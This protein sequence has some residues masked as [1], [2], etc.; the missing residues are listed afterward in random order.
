[1]TAD[2]NEVT[3][4]VVSN[5]NIESEI[6]SE[7][8]VV[9]EEVINEDEP[10]VSSEDEEVP[11]EGEG[12]S[13]VSS[14]EVSEANSEGENEDYGEDNSEDEDESEDEQDDEGED[15]ES[16][17]SSD[18]VESIPVRRSK[19]DIQPPKILTYDHLGEPS[20]QRKF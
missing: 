18:S 16:E 1:M 20:H 17:A 12:E 2:E 14:E 19:R 3:R 13:K 10:E 4:A 5:E 7:N 15:D 6:N 8:E 11:E 9:P